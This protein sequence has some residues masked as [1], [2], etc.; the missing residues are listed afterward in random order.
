MTTA[1]DSDA[2]GLDNERHTEQR[3]ALVASFPGYRSLASMASYSNS[4]PVSTAMASP[5][6]E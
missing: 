4:D 5:S 6:D 3:D 2:V 1:P